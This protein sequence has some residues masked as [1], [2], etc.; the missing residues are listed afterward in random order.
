[1][2]TS[3]GATPT[4]PRERHGARTADGARRNHHR[5][6]LLKEGYARNPAG[7]RLYYRILGEGGPTPVTAGACF[8]QDDLAPLANGRRI[9]FFDRSGRGRSDPVPAD[10]PVTFGSE[11]QDIDAIRTHLGLERF[12]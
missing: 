7:L 8:L 6:R 1:M 11:F 12:A 3:R 5:E 9:V 2:R 4:A 10:M